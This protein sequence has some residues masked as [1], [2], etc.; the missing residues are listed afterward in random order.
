[1]ASTPSSPSAESDDSCLYENVRYTDRPVPRISLR[2]FDARIDCITA[3]ISAAAERHGVFALV[4]HGIS[5]SVIQA[6]FDAAKAFFALPD[7]VKA[8]TPFD[9]ESN[10]GWEQT[11]PASILAESGLG[12]KDREQ[13][14]Y[15]MRL[16]QEHM[17]KQW[18][19]ADTD[20]PG[21]QPQCLSFMQA[22][23]VLS[24]RL[25]VCLARGLGLTDANAKDDQV[26]VKAHDPG[27]S[28]FSQSGLRLQKYFAVGND[29]LSPPLLTPPSPSARST[30]SFRSSRSTTPSSSPAPADASLPR[31]LSSASTSNFRGGCAVQPFSDDAFLTLRFFGPGQTGLEICQDRKFVTDCTV[32]D[33]S[34]WTRIEPAAGEIICSM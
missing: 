33:G 3:E 10:A 25:M 21:F 14:S 4:N 27:V 15:R 7:E 12:D 5:Q 11:P 2:H 34:E 28:S 19:V 17:E 16:G 9:A 31:C 8:K 29:F 18:W 30:R 6:Q 26:F 32:D 24:T 20:L 23:H 1:M 22:C 13:E